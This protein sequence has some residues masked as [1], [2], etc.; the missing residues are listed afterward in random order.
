M[1]Q[2][3]N[4]GI[5]LLRFVLMFMVCVLHVLKQGGILAACE[6]GTADYRCYWL[7]EVLSLC[8]VDGFAII[9]GYM[10]SDRPR[11]YGKL[12][13]MWFQAFFYSFFVTVILMAAGVAPWDGYGILLAA[14]PVTTGR[15]WYFTAFF[16][17][18]LAAPVLNRFLFSIDEKTAGKVFIL[19]LVL[20]S[21]VG[22]FQ[23]TFAA[24]Y[25]YSA[26]WLMILYCIGVLMKRIGLFE[27]VKSGILILIWA[28]SV[29][30][31]WGILLAA[32]KDTVMIKYVSPTILLNGILMVI[33]FSRIRTDGWITSRLTPLVFGIYLLQNNQVIWNSVIKGAF[34][35][36]AGKPVPVGIL[37]VL[38]FAF[39]FVVAG[40]AVEFVRSRAAKRIGIPRLCEKIVSGADSLLEKILGVLMK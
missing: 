11:R 13:E 30:L 20:F 18:F 27:K 9:S 31:T 14:F 7:L 10:A 21:A 19:L 12:G 4:H 1:A 35:F 34:A 29:L 37:C 40:L 25:G 17:L 28:A 15:F 2:E 38:D 24:N 39:V 32:G 5:D 36:I 22:L 6:P 26:L 23:D 8:A 33:L 16:I 3:R